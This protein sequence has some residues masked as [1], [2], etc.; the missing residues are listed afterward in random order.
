MNI[1]FNRYDGM[2]APLR[3]AMMIAAARVIDSGWYLLEKESRAFERAWATYCGT[4]H[5]IGVG[6][7]MDALHIALRAL[8]IG[9]GHEVIVPANTYIATVLA[10]SHAGATPVLVEPRESTFNI[11]PSTFAA[12]ITTRTRAVIPVHLFGQPCEMTEVMAIANAHKLAVIEDNAQAHGARYEGRRTGGWG[13]LNATSFH[14]GKNLGA[15]G[16]AGALTTNDPELAAATRMWGNYGSP[17]K[18]HNEVKGFNSRLD[19]LQAALLALKLERLDGWNSER[20]RLAAVYSDALRDTADLQLPWDVPE[21]EPVY[22]R[23]V[24]RTDERDA[25]QAHLRHAGIETM[26]H[27][28][29]PPHLQPAYHDRTRRAGELPITERMA[30]TSLSIPLYPGLRP[31]EQEYIIEMLASYFR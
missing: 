18:Y 5:A 17:S 3:D 21:A 28:P 6:N 31:D 20:C 12:A 9:S 24:I 7:G 16:D 4:E 1:P 2:H 30:A 19:E 29:I 14:P 11:D 25:L 23:Y 8:G 10:V 27:Y 26:I 22:H 15:L 13:V